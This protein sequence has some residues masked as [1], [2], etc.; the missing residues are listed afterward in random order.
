MISF[1]IFLSLTSTSR[2]TLA[3]W[4]IS[5]FVSGDSSPPR[6]IALRHHAVRV[7]VKVSTSETKERSKV[8]PDSEYL[9]SK[10]GTTMKQ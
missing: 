6:L 5:L 1:M 4:V 10:L 8:S 9:V 7:A 2:G 3:D